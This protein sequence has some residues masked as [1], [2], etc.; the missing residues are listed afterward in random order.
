MIDLVL[1]W[2]GAGLQI[3]DTMPAWLAAFLVGW[4]ASIVITQ[5]LKFVMPLAV[6]Y[7]AR[8]MTSRLIAFFVGLLA[9]GVFYA[10][11]PDAGPGDLVLVM[12]IT[13]AWSPLGFA[14]LIAYLRRGGRES[15]VADVLTQDKRGV[16]AA[17]L[18]GQP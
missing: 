15:F 5:S 8:E 2:W 7:D 6:D 17:K 1:K 3:L 9:S 10:G 18:R 11:R 12:V 16:I 4:V 14:L 13:G